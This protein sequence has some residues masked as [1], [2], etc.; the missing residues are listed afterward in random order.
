MDII[1]VKNT[2][3]GDCFIFCK[4]IE[5]ILLITSSIIIISIL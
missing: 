2:V 1:V 5:Y 3:I 4:D